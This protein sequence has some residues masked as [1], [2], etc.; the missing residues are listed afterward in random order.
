MT[1]VYLAALIVGGVAVLSALAL[2]DLDVAGHDGMPFLDV[3][4]AGRPRRR[5]CR[6]RQRAAL[7]AALQGVLLPYLRHQQAN[8]HRGRTCYIGLLGRVT[9]DVP[10]DAQDAF[11]GLL[12][13]SPLA[14]AKVV[15][16]LKASGVDLA[17]MLNRAAEATTTNGQPVSPAE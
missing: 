13:V 6:A 1:A 5:S 16:A 11:G 8:S 14:V 4:R 15:E 3:G 7:V 10:A 2:T 17:A 12:G 9:L